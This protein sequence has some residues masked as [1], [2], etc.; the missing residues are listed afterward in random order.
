MVPEAIRHWDRKGIMA[1]T[2]DRV[3]AAAL[4]K[5]AAAAMDI[6]VHEWWCDEITYSRRLEDVLMLHNDALVEFLRQT[7]AQSPQSLQPLTT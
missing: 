3:I 7:I 4:R 2:R 5:A 6:D 1:A